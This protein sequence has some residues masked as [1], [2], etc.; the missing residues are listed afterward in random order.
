MPLDPQQVLNEGEQPIGIF[1]EAQN[2]ID[3]LYYGEL[4]GEVADGQQAISNEMLSSYADGAVTIEFLDGTVISMGPNSDLI[5]DEY[6]YDPGTN[7]GKMS[8][9]IVSGLVKFVSGDM[10]SEVL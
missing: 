4:F 6:I 3:R 7:Q 1:F 9:N 5:L 10:S 8:V 2:Q